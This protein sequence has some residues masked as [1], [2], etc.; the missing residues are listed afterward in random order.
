MT[1]PP[2][3]PS[4]EPSPDEP[5]SGAETRIIRR[6]PTGNTGAFPPAAAHDD[7][8][9]TGIIRRTPTGALPV[10]P[11]PPTTVVPQADESATGLLPPVPK[12]GPARPV[13]AVAACVV[14]MVSGWATLVL[15]T[16]LITGWW[17]TDRLFCAAVAFLAFVFAAA[18]ATGII[19]L[20]MRRGLGRYLIAI[21]AVVALLGFGGVFIAGA[22]I[23][24]VVYAIPVLPIASAVL[25]L[26]PAT[27]RWA[28]DPS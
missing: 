26:L 20:L 18:T 8:P 13:T 27:K 2:P 17:S 22:Q 25:A 28:N 24:W 23:P 19:L 10:P 4:P 9:R 1:T 6:A 14:A 21:G 12:P 16:S 15:A 11:A 7:G 3:P 5:P